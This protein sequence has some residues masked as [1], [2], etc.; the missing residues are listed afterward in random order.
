MTM[1]G[2]PPATDPQTQEKRQAPERN[3]VR[4]RMVSA[5]GEAL[6]YVSHLDMQ[7]VWER[8]LRRAGV[9]LAFSQGFSPRPRL[10]MAAALPLGFR[11]RCE[12]TDIWLDLPSGE[13]LNLPALTAQVQASA[14]PGLD[15]LSGEVV[16][17][18]LPS[19]QTL[20]QSAEYL[21]APLDPLGAGTLEEAARTLLAAPA[22]PRERRGKTYDLRPLVE[23]LEVRADAQPP[24]LFMRL[25]A[26]EGA[27]G[28][29]EEVLSAMG[30]D[31]AEFRVERTMLILNKNGL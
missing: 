6:R 15:I 8:T 12:I 14:P 17:L 29:P 10:H 11:S 4:V 18:N 23:A 22:I 5:R 13:T 26:R 7:L 31:P 27:T 19:L 16:P 20:V 9:P 3:L 2:Q 28:R 1:N 21:A 24:A 30:F 25:T